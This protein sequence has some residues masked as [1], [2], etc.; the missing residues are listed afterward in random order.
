[1]VNI[2]KYITLNKKT[3]ANTKNKYESLTLGRIRKQKQIES[4]KL[5]RIRKPKQISVNEVRS[6]KKTE[7]NMSH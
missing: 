6:I 7:A 1:M 2:S 4:M 3:E 5:G